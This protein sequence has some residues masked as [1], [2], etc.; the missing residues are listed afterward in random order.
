MKLSR[1]GLFRALIGAP[2]AAQLPT[3]VLR[4]WQRLIPPGRVSKVC[5]VTMD[6]FNRAWNEMHPSMR[7]VD[8]AN[9]WAKRGYQ[10]LIVPVN[11][12]I[13]LYVRSVIEAV[14]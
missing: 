1:R 8:D 14:K 13:H 9:A 12:R 2:V 11:G 4:I 6:E 5:H 10:T 3:S 7:Y